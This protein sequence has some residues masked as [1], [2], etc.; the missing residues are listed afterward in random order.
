[1]TQVKLYNT[2]GTESKTISLPKQFEEEINADLIKRAV[3]VIQNGNRNKYGIL[4]GAGMRSSAKLSRRRKKYRGG[5]GKSMSRVPRKILWR[6]GTQFGME[7]A[8]VSGMKGG[9][10]AHAPKKEKNFEIKINK[11]ERRKAIRSAL[12]ATIIENLVSSK[13]KVPKAFPLIIENKLES[14]DKTK[15]IKDLLLKLGFENEMTRLAIKKVRAGRGKSRNRKY[16]TRTGPLIVVSKDC[17]L[18]KAA[19]NLQG[20]EISQV[21]KLNAELLAP[22]AVPGRLIIWSEDA[23]SRLDK[24]KLFTNSPINVKREK[25]EE[26][27]EAKPVK[28][29][30]KVTK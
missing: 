9:R 14:F 19:K 11:K 20:F 24:E 2:Q 15:Q 17:S 10:K 3:F 23:I 5:Y 12:S 8:V 27:L 26:K 22:G 18:E 25:A 28:K 13:H 30:E 16:K 1:M 21:H 29:V 7:G 6:R 4:K